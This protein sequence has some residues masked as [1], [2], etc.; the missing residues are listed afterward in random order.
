MPIFISADIAG[1]VGAAGSIIGSSQQANAA[2]NAA[3]IQSGMFG[4]TV[5]NEQPFINA[6]KLSQAQLN[7]LLGTGAPGT[8]NIARGSTAGGFGSLTA[9]F[10]AANWKSLS[11][12]YGFQLQ[13][14]MQGVVNSDASGSGA[15]G[16]AALKDLIGYNQGMANTSFNN[17]FNQYQTQQGNIYARLMGVA[18]QGQAAASNQATGASNFGS[19]I[20]ASTAAAGTATGGGTVGAA[21]ALGGAANTAALYGYLGQS[22]NTQ[23]GGYASNFMNQQGS[24]PASVNYNSQLSSPVSSGYDAFGNPLG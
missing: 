24:G 23:A 5:G 6:G 8:G 18:N 12:A 16:G 17:A 15:T 4:E 21:N 14:G 11:P 7:Y 9:P 22:A 3:N 10:T 1:G 2:T 20:G 19:S 13:Q